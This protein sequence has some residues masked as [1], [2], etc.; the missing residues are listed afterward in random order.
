VMT[1]SAVTYLK[2]LAKMH[3]PGEAMQAGLIQVNNFESLAAFGE[4]FPVS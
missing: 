1:Q 3:D 2:T 4:L